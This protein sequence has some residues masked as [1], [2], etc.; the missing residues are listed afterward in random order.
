MNNL[1]GHNRGHNAGHNHGQKSCDQ[2]NWPF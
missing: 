2:L 1:G